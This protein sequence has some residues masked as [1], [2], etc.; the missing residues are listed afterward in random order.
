LPIALH[1]VVVGLSGGIGGRFDKHGSCL[2]RLSINAIY[3]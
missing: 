1:K 3:Y 2:P